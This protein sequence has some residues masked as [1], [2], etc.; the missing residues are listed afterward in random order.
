MKK[1]LLLSMALVTLA[2]HLHA[3]QALFLSGADGVTNVV[4]LSAIDSLSFSAD[5]S[6]LN[7]AALGSV[8]T[9]PCDQILSL[10]LDES[11]ESFLVT[12]S[13]PTASAINPYFAQGVSVSIQGADVVV[14]NDNTTEELTFELGGTSADGSFLYNASFKSTLV[15]NNL[16]LTSS[17]G[18]A[19]DIQCGKR[20]SLQLKKDSDNRLED[21]AHGEQK[22]ALYCK[23]HLEFDKSG[24]LTVIGH[25]KHAISAKEYI[26]LKKSDGTIIVQ[27]STGDGIH[28]SQYFLA[29]G[30][31]VQADI[32]NG[33]GIQA[34]ASELIPYEEEYPDGSL[35][36]QGGSFIINCTGDGVC[37]L[38]ADSDIHINAEKSVPV[39]QITV[40]G[41][42]SKK[43]KA[44]GQVIIAEGL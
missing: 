20:V 35:W 42:D 16:N 19:M 25:T 24:R 2:S 7:I 13:G 1:S 34:Q 27:S 14:N 17:K 39:I 9:L 11:P 32:Q 30:F 15:L 41:T 6:L 12:Y 22:A 3:G 18:A 5:G 10:R 31:N 37:G 26:Q 28:C 38:K 40:S 4:E 29:N 33:D 43:M 21:C 8:K 36:I 23:G 44:S